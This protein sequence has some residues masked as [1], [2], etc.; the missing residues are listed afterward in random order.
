VDYLVNGFLASVIQS[1]Q[2]VLTRE[3]PSMDHDV[4][5]IGSSVHRGQSIDIAG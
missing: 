2:G 3:P 5:W 4:S 1:E